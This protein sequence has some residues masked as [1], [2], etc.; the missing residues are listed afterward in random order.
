[1]CP[2]PW[3]AFLSIWRRNFSG[4]SSGSL[5]A[6]DTFN[7]VLFAGDSD[8]L[9]PRPMAATKANLE[10]AVALLSNHSGSGGTELIAGMRKALALPS[11]KDVSRSLVLISDGYISAESEVFE[12]IRNGANGTNI[13]PLGVGSS[14][15]R[16]LMDGLARIAGNDSFIVTHPGETADAVGRFR[17]AVS[18]PVLTGI[19]VK[20]EGFETSDFQ[21]RK[22]PDLFANRPLSLI[23]KWKGKP[24]G[25]LTLSGT[26]GEG[27]TYEQTFEVSEAAGE[28]D[29]P[30][31]PT[32]WARETVRGLADYA[33]L[34]GKPEIIE[35]VS[36]V[37]LKYELL[38]P[39]T[40]FVAVDDVP[41]EAGNAPV[42]VKQR[43]PLPAGVGNG[44]VGGSVPE[45]DTFLM[46]ALVLIATSLLRIR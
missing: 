1:M 21:P 26:T 46:I 30:S 16:H 17:T 6:T 45:P 34:T 36:R 14:V 31:L 41:R 22:L 7:V 40:S 43:L 18:S 5:R 13:F 25:T 33:E 3:A 28:M 10:R 11:D 37:G 24:G 38:T 27:K 4:I 44:G 9:S 35:E 39:Y 29:N 2:A 23:G 20:A 8:I 42:P 19:T 12:M 15:N 32:L